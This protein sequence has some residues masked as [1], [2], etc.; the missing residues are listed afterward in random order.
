VR[1]LP[2]RQMILKLREIH[3]YT[4][5]LVH[6]D[7]EEAP[8]SGPGQQTK[9]PA[10]TS[11]ARPLSYTQQGP[12]FKQPRPPTGSSPG[13]RGR[14]EDDAAPL[15]SSQGSNT[16]STTAASEESER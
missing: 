9:P 16:S 13:K 12:H 14:E 4:H 7:E 11:S 15:S 5:Q 2:K 8:L 1:P 3:Q 10:T 6:S